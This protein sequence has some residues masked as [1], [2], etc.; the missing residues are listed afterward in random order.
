ML[1]VRLE[2]LALARAYLLGGQAHV[3]GNRRRLADRRY[4]GRLLRTTVAVDHQPRVILC[5]QWRIQSGGHALSHGQRADVPGDMPLEIR[6][7]KTQRCQALRDAPAGMIDGNHE[8]RPAVP[9]AGKNRGWLVRGQQVQA[10]D[11]RS[12][13]HS[14]RSRRPLAVRGRGTS[15]AA[16]SIVVYSTDL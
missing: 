16:L 14:M 9:P 12:R 11:E 3:S 13:A 2:D 8:G 4:G 7:R 6:L 1:V 15:V 5:N 10:H